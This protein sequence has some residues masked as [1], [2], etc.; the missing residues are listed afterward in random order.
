MN[1]ISIHKHI[2]RYYVITHICVYKYTY[3]HICINYIYHIRAVVYIDL[4]IVPSYTAE[5]KLREISITSATPG[6]NKLYICMHVYTNVN[7][8][9]STYGRRHEALCV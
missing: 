7:L 8:D 5:I 4:I 9:R 3:V 1:I 2:T 6:P